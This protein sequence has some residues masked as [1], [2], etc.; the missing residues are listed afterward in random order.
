[1]AETIKKKATTPSKPRKAAAPKKI[2]EGYSDDRF[3]LKK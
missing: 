2:G 3:P 1:M